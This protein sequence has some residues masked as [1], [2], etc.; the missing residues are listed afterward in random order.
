MLKDDELKFGAE[1]ARSRHAALLQLIYFT[2]QQAMALLRLYVTLGLATASGALAGFVSQ[3]VPRVAAWGLLA[4]L[5]TLVAGS[6]FCFR[7]MMSSSV[8]LPGRGAEFWLW[9]EREATVDFHHVLSEY[10]IQLEKTTAEDRE[11]NKRNVAALRKAKLIGMTVPLTAL[12]G[13]AA[14]IGLR[15]Y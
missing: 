6:A 15:I 14:A 11:L 3:A 1:D 7:V 2:D 8:G 10:L 9:A 5:V 12:L 4:G 13:A